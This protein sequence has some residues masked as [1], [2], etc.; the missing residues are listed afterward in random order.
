MEFA[1]S[2]LGVGVVLWVQGVP[3]YLA[4]HVPAIRRATSVTASSKAMRQRKRFF[5]TK[6]LIVSTS[7]FSYLVR[8]PLE[9]LKHLDSCE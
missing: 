5:P 2:L 1:L 9:C 4:R 8:Y 3:G 7:L 6:L